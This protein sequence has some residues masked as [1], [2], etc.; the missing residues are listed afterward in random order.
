MSHFGLGL[1]GGLPFGNDAFTKVLLHVDGANG[2]TT[3]PDDNALGL[4]HTFTPTNATT[5]TANQ[6]FGPSSMLTAAGFIT[7]PD[8]TDFTL[9]SGD[10]TVDYWFNAN[11][12]AFGVNKYLAG[13]TSAGNVAATSAWDFFATPAAFSFEVFQGGANVLLNGAINF[14]GTSSWNHVAAVRNGGTL[15]L[16]LNGTSAASSAIAGSV[17]NSPASLSVGRAGDATPNPWVGYIDEFRLS[18]GV[19]RWTS[20]F[21]PPTAPYA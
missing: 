17:N 8:S 6:K 19:A 21:T 7:T 9:G 18:V 20:N 5:S 4:S 2:G 1:I 10:F 15:T 12:N 11:G 16:Y 14:S 3:F 13:Q